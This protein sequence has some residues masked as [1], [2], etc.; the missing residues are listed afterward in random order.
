MDTTLSYTREWVKLRG[1]TVSIILH[2]LA[3]TIHREY[4]VAQP[5]EIAYTYYAWKRICTVTIK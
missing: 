2:K 1:K 5:I 4:C 3:K